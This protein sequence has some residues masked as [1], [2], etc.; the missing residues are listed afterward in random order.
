MQGSDNISWGKFNHQMSFSF[1]FLV[2]NIA[3]DGLQTTTLTGR[4]TKRVSKHRYLCT[5][6]EQKLAFKFHTDTFAT[7]LNKNRIFIQKP[8]RLPFALLE[9]DDW[10]FLPILHYGDVIHRH[11]STSTLTPQDSGFITGASYFTRHR[12]LYNEAGWA[13]RDTIRIG[14]FSFLEF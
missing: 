9:K 2:R 12:I 11:A 13:S 10:G 3:D 6:L 7:N 4:S 1:S 8:I 14:S 5:F